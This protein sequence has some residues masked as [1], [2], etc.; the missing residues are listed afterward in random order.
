M[1]YCTAEEAPHANEGERAHAAAQARTQVSAAA[2]PSCGSEVG[3][4]LHI[5]Q[6]SLGCASTDRLAAC[7][8]TLHVQVDCLARAPLT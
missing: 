4:D 6:F 7:L 1:W 3:D 5:M 8:R 2:V